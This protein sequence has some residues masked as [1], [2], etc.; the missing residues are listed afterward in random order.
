[1]GRNRKE[2]L[3]DIP[4]LEQASRE[5]VLKTAVRMLQEIGY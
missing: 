2:P 3:A 1:M 5:T 4:L